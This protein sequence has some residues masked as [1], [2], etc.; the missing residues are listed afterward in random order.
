MAQAT[1]PLGTVDEVDVTILVDNSIDLLMTSTEVSRRHPLGR[2]P[3][4]HPQ[5]IANTAHCT[6]WIATHALAHAMPQAFV[7]TS[8]GTR[9]HLT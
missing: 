7:A 2:H 8:V 6:G 1:L 3:F 5:P 4:E 9:I